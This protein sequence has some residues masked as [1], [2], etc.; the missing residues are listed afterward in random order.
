MTK[1][2]GRLWMAGAVWWR[3]PWYCDEWNEP[4]LLVNDG[5]AAID[6]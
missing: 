5:F 1:K 6:D 4:M 3:P 2:M